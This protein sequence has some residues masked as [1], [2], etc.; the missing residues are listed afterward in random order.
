MATKIE[1]FRI[2]IH[3]NS[4]YTEYSLQLLSQVGFYKNTQF[5]GVSVNCDGLNP[6]YHGNQNF[7][8]SGKIDHNLGCDRSKIVVASWGEGILRSMNFNCG[9]LV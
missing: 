6:R 2:K 9:V 7:W 3:Y 1:I 5:N 8:N 4:G